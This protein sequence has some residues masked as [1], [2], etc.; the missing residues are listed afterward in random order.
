MMKVI[1]NFQAKITEYQQ[2]LFLYTYLSLKT[3]AHNIRYNRIK[4]IKTEW[5][6]TNDTIQDKQ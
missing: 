2:W 5:N 3:A 6:K 1:Q 4:Q